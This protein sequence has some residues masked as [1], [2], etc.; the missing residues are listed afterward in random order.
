MSKTLV[1]ILLCSLNMKAFGQ[2]SE[3]AFQHYGLSD[4]M[5]D[6]TI[7]CVHFDKRGFLWIGTNEGLNRF[8]GENFFTLAKKTNESESLCGNSI[9]TIEEDAAGNIWVG[10][11]DAGICR[12]RNNLKVD[13]KPLI[14][15]SNGQEIQY[16]HDILFDHDSTMY[17]AT[18]KGLFFSISPYE[19][20][21]ESNP[22]IPRACYALLQTKDGILTSFITHTLMKLNEGKGTTLM[23]IPY[24]QDGHTMQFFYRTLSG[25][26]VAGGWDPCLHEYAER[27]NLLMSKRISDK[28]LITQ[29]DEIVCITEVSPDVLWLAMKSGKILRHDL[30]RDEFS[31]LSISDEETKRLNGNRIFCMF[32]DPFQRIWIGTDAGLHVYNPLNSKFDITWLPDNT[33]KVLSFAS[34]KNDMLAGTSKGLFKIGNFGLEKQSI[35]YH[36]PYSAHSIYSTKDHVYIGTSDNLLELKDGILQPVFA[37]HPANMREIKS[38]LFNAISE[39][40]I[41][42]RNYLLTNPYGHGTFLASLE[43]ND[44]LGGVVVCNGQIDH[45]IKNILQDSKGRTWFLG[46]SSGIGLFENCTLLD[47]GFPTEKWNP[48]AVGA[49]AI[50][51]NSKIYA[52]AG[53]TR[54]ISAMVENVDGTFWVGSLGSGLLL[55]DPRKDSLFYTQVENSPS[56]VYQI[57]K[58]RQGLIWMTARGGIFSFNPETQEWLKFDEKDGIPSAG[59]SN[60][61]F[62]QGNGVMYAGGNGFYLSFEPDKKIM[63][64]ELPHT[65]ITG[66]EVMGSSRDSL[67]YVSNFSL[68]SDQNFITFHFTSLCF[69]NASNSTFEYMLEGLDPTWRSSG[70]VNF[71][72]YNKLPFG[73]YTF[74]V[75]SFSSSGVMDIGEATVR[76]TIRAPFYYSTWF[77]GLMIVSFAAIVFVLLQYRNNQKKKLTVMRDKIARDLHDDVGSA[78]GSI[79][80]YSETARKTLLE[81]KNEK[82]ADIIQRMGYTSRQ[83]IENMHD[84][85]WAVQSG[86]DSVQHLLDRMQSVV[87]ELSSDHNFQIRFECQDDIKSLKMDMNMRKNC[88]LIFKEAIYNSMK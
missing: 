69:N 6:N 9:T 50:H 7:T 10:T 76:F 20:F 19:Q 21:S 2:F 33:T 78:L 73:A 47:A 43:A 86:N 3:I 54:E 52:Q 13:Q 16:V 27:D 30:Q 8:D 74:R 61:L 59:L 63:N 39:V 83:M 31:V 14:M 18:D 4:G 70:T 88:Y 26:I 81:N 55:F 5:S 1:F 82:T 42:G 45:L 77:I 60:C 17:V 40:K 28:G 87:A 23:S 53:V 65:A 41:A 57:V 34:A 51:F 38:T 66:I 75:R 36:K 68:P 85:V 44:W 79:S 11:R 29:D 71:V 67:C 37:K 64:P 80:F 72:D 12:V 25:K 35:F 84:I 32:T 22:F 15:S 62:M 56:S 49:E 24:P 58:D 46:T 48:E